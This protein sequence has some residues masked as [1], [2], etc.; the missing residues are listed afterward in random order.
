MLSIWKCPERDWILPRSLCEELQVSWTF[1]DHLNGIT[2][3]AV[4][5]FFVCSVAP[6][7]PSWM[8]SW[9]FLS[10]TKQA[11]FGSL[12]DQARTTLSSKS[13]MVHPRNR[14]FQHLC[15]SQDTP[16]LLSS[17]G[18][19]SPLCGDQRENSWVLGSLSGSAQKDEGNIKLQVWKLISWVGPWF[20]FALSWQM[21][22][23]S[24]EVNMLCLQFHWHA[25]YR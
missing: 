22:S 11:T 7:A 14:I 5:K 4:Y 24:Q 15:P 3:L 13:A 18:L 2:L 9:F 1:L 10:A 20:A 23:S 19:W 17:L 25:T 6:I 16:R 12:E 21:L 8:L